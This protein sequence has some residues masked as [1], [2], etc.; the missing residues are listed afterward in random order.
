MI[1]GQQNL[2]LW[3]GRSWRKRI[4][5]DQRRFAYFLWPHFVALGVAK[6]RHP[7]RVMVVDKRDVYGQI[8]HSINLEFW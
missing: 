2:G 8:T 3:L 4:T 6:G 7:D 1:G 5:I